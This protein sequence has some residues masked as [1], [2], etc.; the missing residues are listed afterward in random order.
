MEVAMSKLVRAGL[1]A[2]MITGASFVADTQASYG[3][4]LRDRLSATELENLTDARIAILKFALQLTPAQEKDWPAVEQA[5]RARAAGRQARLAAAQ[6]RASEMRNGNAIENV[7][8]RDP[9]EFLNRRAD[10]LAQRSAELRRLADAWQPLY[11][12]LSADQRKRL[13]IVAVLVFRDLRDR[14]EER[15]LKGDDDDDND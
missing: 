6:A 13:G 4:A 5:I 15:L 2:L 11:Q 7:R 9:I 8:N 14:D 1:T 10:A 3:Q 12:T